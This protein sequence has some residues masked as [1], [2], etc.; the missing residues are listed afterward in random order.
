M[1]RR[2]A[3]LLVTILFLMPCIAWAA[4]PEDFK[5]KTAGALLDLCAAPPDS[6]LYKEAIH[7]C[8]GFLV[9]A[10]AYHVAQNSGPEGKMLV[11]F[12]DPPPAR[13]DSVAMFVDWL[14]A[15]PEFMNDKPVEAEFRFL[16]E[17]WP[18]KR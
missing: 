1:K 12:P 7:F 11:C 14:K 6:P 16:I 9:G 13:N 17:K 10:Y 8:H 18:C 4:S 3:F 5:V 15:H 2:L